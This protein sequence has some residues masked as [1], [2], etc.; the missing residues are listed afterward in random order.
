MPYKFNIFTGKFDIVSHSLLTDDDHTQYT[1]LSGR[2]TPQ[3]IAFGTAASATAGYLTSTSHATKGSY[4]LNAA[5][6]I[7]VDELN[8]RIGIGA[9]PTYELDIQKDLVGGLVGRIRNSAAGTGSFSQLTLGNDG[10]F[11]V[12]LQNLSTTWTTA[13]I[14]YANGGTLVAQGTGGLSIA[15]LHSAGGAI[16]FYAGGTT[17]RWRI[18]ATGTLSNTGV[19]GTAY[20]HLKAGTTAASTAP[21]KLTSGSLMTTAEAGAIEFLTDAY[22]G[23][24]TT[25]AARKT[26]A[27]TDANHNSLSNLTVGDVH[28]HYALLAGRSGGQTLIGGTGVTDILNLQGTSGNGTATSPAIKFKVGNNGAL[29]AG[30]FTNKGELILGSATKPNSNDFALQI[31]AP[32]GSPYIQALIDATKTFGLT[33]NYNTS[34]GKFH[35]FSD[36]FSG[37]IEPGFVIGTYTNQSNQLVLIKTNGNIG[38]G[39]TAPLAVLHLKAGTATA[40]TGQIKLDASTLLTTPEAGTIERTTDDLQFT[41][42]TGAARK[43][44]VLDN[45]TALTSG[46]VP[47]A[48]TN[49]RLTDD[50][51]F[52]FATDTLTATKIVGTTSVKAGTAAGFISSDGSTGATG[53]FT[54]ADLKTVTVK[55]GIITVIA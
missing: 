15:A 52:T 5:G 14:N 51:D 10:N 53:T 24:I 46:R 45:G 29:T 7:V 3:T 48:T 28:T 22:Y 38:F 44:I 33:Y 32:T 36:Y 34:D 40:S 49:G 21:I 50:A 6:T 37:T 42:G 17:E 27:F 11:N 30:Y 19:A 16:R 18:A 9:T 13:G 8:A 43:K 20:I 26:F 25:G 4:S 47:F 39:V 55:D 1:L 41:I 35:I 31:V 54:T 12:N 2:A 23:T